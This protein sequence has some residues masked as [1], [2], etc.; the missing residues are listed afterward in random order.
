MLSALT[1]SWKEDISKLTRVYAELTTI[2]TNLVSTA[3]IAIKHEDSV[4]Y[5]EARTMHRRIDMLIQAEFTDME[6]MFP[7][8]RAEFPVW[9]TEDPDAE[10]NPFVFFMD[11]PVITVEDTAD[12]PF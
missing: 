3:R 10:V 6:D 5:S 12:V 4:R 8:M 2:R 7:T 1:Q 9:N 11:D